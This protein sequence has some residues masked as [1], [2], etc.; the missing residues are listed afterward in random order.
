MRGE[1]WGGGLK[2]WRRAEENKLEKLGVQQKQCSSSLVFMEHIF[3]LCTHVVHNT[4]RQCTT[5][6]KTR[7]SSH[8][9]LKGCLYLSRRWKYPYL[10]SGQHKKEGKCKA[11]LKLT[12]TLLP[13]F[14]F[15]LSVI[16]VPKSLLNFGHCD[17]STIFYTILGYVLTKCFRWA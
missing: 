13:V 14:F 4:W 6:N 1:V 9:V 10:L 5:E 3:R 8:P 17:A 15:I 11:C 12:Q 7:F 16:F 2:G